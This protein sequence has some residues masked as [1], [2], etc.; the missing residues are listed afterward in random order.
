MIIHV[1][2]DVFDAGYDVVLH[3]A[4]T[5]ATMGSGIAYSIKN[6]F[7]SVYQ[8]DKEF[9][10]PVGRGRLGSFSYATVPKRHAPEETFQ[11][12]NLYGQDNWT[13]ASVLTEYDAFSKALHGIFTYLKNTYLNYKEFR[14]AVPYLIG[15]DRAGGDWNK[16]SNLLEEVSHK[17]EIPIYV[18]NINID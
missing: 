10:I 18:S 4:N 2:G 13:G 8:A 6:E 1:K 9:K 17:F 5:R 11:I 7:P 15:C 16:V 14:V 12:F 3:Q